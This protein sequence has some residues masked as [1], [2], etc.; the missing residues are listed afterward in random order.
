MY[1]SETRFPQIRTA[2]VVLRTEVAASHLG[3]LHTRISM[4]MK[5]SLLLPAFVLGCLSTF[6]QDTAPVITQSPVSQ[7]VSPGASVT[8]SV[9][10]TGD[11]LRYQWTYNGDVIPGATETALT[12][13]SVTTESSGAY[14]A[15][16]YNDADLVESDVADVLVAVPTLPFADNFASR[17]VINSASGLGSAT[18]LDASKEPG[19]PKPVKGPLAS[20]VWLTWI[21]PGSG[22]ATFSTIGS[23]FDT[24]LGVYTGTALSNLVAVASDD[25]SGGYHASFVTF[26]AQAGTAYQIYVGSRDRD[27]G[28]ILLSWALNAPI[29]SLPTIT[30]SPTNITT[31]V[32]TAASMCVQFQSAAPLTIQ[33]YLNGQPIPGANQNCLQWSQLT[34]ADLGTYQVSLS[35]PDWTWSLS[36]VEIQFNTEGLTTV[37][38]RNKLF[39]SI[40]SAL[41]GK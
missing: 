2:L 26:N 15:L 34:V 41:I 7:I 24:M 16:V 17:G 39:D 5:T 1:E 37:A 30:S 25:D 13:P 10:A 28:S 36:P 27:G 31:K 23:A 19:D 6:A 40:N 20:S 21:A 8:L 11:A 4:T 29:Y 3:K 12:L 35:S 9:T 38:A 18:S 32:G 33:W 22:V 14:Q